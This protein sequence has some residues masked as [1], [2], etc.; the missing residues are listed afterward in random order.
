MRHALPV[1]VLVALLMPVHGCSFGGGVHV[2]SPAPAIVSAPITGESAASDESVTRSDIPAPGKNVVRS[3]IPAPGDSSGRPR[4]QAPDRRAV[5]RAD[6][7]GGFAATADWE[8]FANTRRMLGAE[9]VRRAAILHERAVGNLGAELA[10]LRMSA[11]A[12]ELIDKGSMDGALELLERALSMYA[13]NGYA[14]LFLAYVHHVEGRP[15]RATGFIGSARR[16]LPA[17]KGVRGEVEGLARSIRASGP[18]ASA[19][20]PPPTG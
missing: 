15:D 2:E 12:P 16:Y 1:A 13:G 20:R 6:E 11:K 3:N 9:I 17:D 19:S 5:K 7:S 4:D 10:S 8:A 14:Y 18:G